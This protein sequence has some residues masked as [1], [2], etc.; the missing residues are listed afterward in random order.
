MNK[1]H[2]FYIFRLQSEAI[3]CSLTISD[4]LPTILTI[5]AQLTKDSKFL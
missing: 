3:V 4:E 5:R 2:R 1:F